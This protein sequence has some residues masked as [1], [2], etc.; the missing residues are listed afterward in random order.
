[1]SDSASILAHVNRRLFRLLVYTVYGSDAAV[2]YL[3]QAP[4]S[5]LPDFE[6]ETSNQVWKQAQATLQTTQAQ[7]D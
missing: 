3:N 6:R 5:V 1:M 7:S 2:N 4:A